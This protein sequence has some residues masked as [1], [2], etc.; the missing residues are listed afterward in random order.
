MSSG[1]GTRRSARRRIAP[2]R[3]GFIAGEEQLRDMDAQLNAMER[4]RTEAARDAASERAEAARDA[5]AEAARARSERAEAARG[6]IGGCAGCAAPRLQAPP[7]DCAAWRK[8]G[9][10]INHTIPRIHFTTGER[11][12]PVH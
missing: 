5:R 3:E 8:L 1:D 10:C 7:A 11:S 4:T 2:P 9:A 12:E 6:G